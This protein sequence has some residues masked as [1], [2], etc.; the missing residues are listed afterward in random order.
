[1]T[2]IEDFELISPKLFNEFDLVSEIIES[3]CNWISFSVEGSFMFSELSCSGR[4][5]DANNLVC[6]C[7]VSK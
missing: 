6:V 4:N 7:R 5:V 3:I 2:S 1:M